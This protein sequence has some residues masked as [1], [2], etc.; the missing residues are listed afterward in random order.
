MIMKK[1]VLAVIGIISV[2]P[3]LIIFAVFFQEK[4]NIQAQEKMQEKPEQKTDWLT[5]EEKELIQKVKSL[6]DRIETAMK[7]KEPKWK[8]KKKFSGQLSRGLIPEEKGGGEIKIVSAY[9]QFK[10]NGIIADVNFNTREPSTDKEI[11]QLWK[12]GLRM[13]SR[14]IVNNLEI[15]DEGV[16]VTDVTESPSNYVYASFRKGKILIR[17][18]INSRF[19]NRLTHEKEAKKIAEI[20]DSIIP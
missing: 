18:G 11:S 7:E 2:L 4:P 1:N 19:G 6:A 9:L 10:K 15:G 14:G 8:L 16:V 3:V 13:M 5:A 17:V 20:I 12:S